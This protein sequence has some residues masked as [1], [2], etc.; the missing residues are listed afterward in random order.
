M[1]CHGR[2]RCAVW[3]TSH[4]K[5]EAAGSGSSDGDG[6]DRFLQSFVDAYILG[7]ADHCL[8]VTASTF[9]QV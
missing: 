5:P 6:A 8:P 3:H 4:S 2:G 1:G 9:P 7:L